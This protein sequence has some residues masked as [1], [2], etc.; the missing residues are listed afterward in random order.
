MNYKIANALTNDILNLIIFPT[1]QCN[2]RCFYCYESFELGKMNN[3]VVESILK[4]VKKRA[5]SLKELNISW[6]GGEPL[7]AKDIV[8]YLSEEFK[9]MSEEFNFI[10]NGAMTTNGYY[11]DVQL[12]KT[13]VDL[14][15]TSYQITL[16]GSKNSHDKIR[17]MKNKKGSFDTIWNNLLS[18]KNIDSRFDIML[19]IHYTPLTILDIKSFASILV[20]TFKNDNRFNLFF[21]NV[22]K[23][24]STNDD[25]LS[26]CTNNETLEYQM[27]LGLLAKDFNVVKIEP[28]YI[29]YASKAN[30]YMIRS[31]GSV[32]KCTVALKEDVNNIGKLKSNGELE[33]DQDKFRLWSIGLQ[34]EDSEHLACPYYNLIKPEII[35]KYVSEEKGVR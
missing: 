17:I 12:L 20:D 6:F 13:L 35:D 23:L 1:E 25:N 14:G 31:D 34:T 7:M 11:L 19:R 26:I 21:K 3:E 29:C 5:S 18:F 24:G 30:S 22:S 32:G 2:F 10:Y 28:D 4:L 16:D 15:I 9:K 27:E 33:L 8:L